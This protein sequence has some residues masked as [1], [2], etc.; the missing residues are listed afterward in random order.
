MTLTSKQRDAVRHVVVA[1]R[2]LI[3][4]DQG[5]TMG[6]NIDRRR[7]A[8]EVRGQCPMGCGTTLFLGVGGHVTCSLL[9]CPR[10]GAADEL[11]SHD[12][13]HFAVFTEPD[14]MRVEH[15]PRELLEG[16]IDACTAGAY[17]RRFYGAPMKP[18]RYRLGATPD[19]WTF[20]A[21]Q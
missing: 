12:D 6:P 3:A 4:T 2:V 13:D 15:P 5:A 16:V 19:G 21:T 10:P 17:L 20:Q 8:S 11:L 9:G 1:R 7:E 18:G 14:E